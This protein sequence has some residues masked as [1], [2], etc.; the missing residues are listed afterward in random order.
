MILPVIYILLLWVE[1]AWLYNVEKHKE[2]LIISAQNVFK[3]GL[4]K[5]RISPKPL[6]IPILNL[7]NLD[8]STLKTENSNVSKCKIQ[9]FVSSIFQKANSKFTVKYFFR[10]N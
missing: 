10:L 1:R 3:E 7:I 8:Y 4:K 9:N 5:N 2:S 6:T